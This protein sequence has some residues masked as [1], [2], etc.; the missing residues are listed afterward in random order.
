MPSAKMEKRGKNI[1]VTSNRSPNGFDLK[2]KDL[3]IGD[4]DDDLLS[5]RKILQQYD[6]VMG[7]INRKDILKHHEESYKKM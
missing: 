4:P 1:P 5:A 6:E 2:K 3:L 7:S